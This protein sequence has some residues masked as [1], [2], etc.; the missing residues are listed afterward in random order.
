MKFEKINFLILQLFIVKQILKGISSQSA[1][2][3]R[4]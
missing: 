3:W 2:F 4:S 1:L